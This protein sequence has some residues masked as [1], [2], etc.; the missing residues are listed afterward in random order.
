VKLETIVEA[1][2]KLETMEQLSAV[3]GAVMSRREVVMS[4]KAKAERGRKMAEARK[5][6]W[7]EGKYDHIRGAKVSKAEA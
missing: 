1:V 2:R 6:A 7:A 3:Q 4:D 5:K